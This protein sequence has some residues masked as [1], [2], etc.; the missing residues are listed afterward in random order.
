MGDIYPKLTSRAMQKNSVFSFFLLFR[1]SYSLC[2]FTI[3]SALP[4]EEPR[5][6][7]AARLGDWSSKPTAN[8]RPRLGPL[9]FRRD[10]CYKTFYKTVEMDLARALEISRCSIRITNHDKNYEMAAGI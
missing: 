8:A 1:V 6:V 2:A 3:F 5:G 7:N 10:S 9:L 4:K